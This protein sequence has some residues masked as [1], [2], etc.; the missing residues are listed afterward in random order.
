MFMRKYDDRPADIPDLALFFAGKAQSRKC[1]AEPE[2][3]TQR[4]PT[5]A[6]FRQGGTLAQRLFG[7][8]Y[9]RWWPWTD[10]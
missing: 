7:T 4:T 9:L 8:A 3:A 5:W 10:L 2:A 6:C 1:G